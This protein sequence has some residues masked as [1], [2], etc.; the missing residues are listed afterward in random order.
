MVIFYG[1]IE[2]SLQSL[3]IDLTPTQYHKFN[4]SS[5][6][7]LLMAPISQRRWFIGRVYISILRDFLG[8][9]IRILSQRQV[10]IRK[11]GKEE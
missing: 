2:T 3:S 1:P 4:G 9:D 7:T 5:N 11:I 6:T 8:I 10:K